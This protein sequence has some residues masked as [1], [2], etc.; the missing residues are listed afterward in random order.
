MNYEDDIRIDESS[1][2]VEWLEQPRLMMKYTRHAVDM[3]QVMDLARENLDL[4]KAELDKEIRND[5]ES[6]GLAKITEGAINNTIIAQQEY[7]TASKQYLDAKYEYEV[8]QG[9][10]RAFDQRKSALEN[11]VRLHGQQYFAGPS[12]P[13]DLNEEVEKRKHQV[14]KNVG[15][16]LKRRTRTKH[17]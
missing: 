13:R 1:L 7:K 3:R 4:C 17:S 2:D 9:A 6:F 5:P 8:A 10:V 12:I 15:G 14:N 11:L 16:T